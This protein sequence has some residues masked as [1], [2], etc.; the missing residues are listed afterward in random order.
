[1]ENTFAQWIKG[2]YTLN[3]LE[4]KR[5]YD[6]EQAEQMRQQEKSDFSSLLTGELSQLGKEKNAWL[7]LVNLYPE[8]IFEEFPQEKLVNARDEKGELYFREVLQT[9]LKRRPDWKDID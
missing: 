8:Q 1:M 3:L 2:Y 9:A 4:Q 5:E 7:R 6:E